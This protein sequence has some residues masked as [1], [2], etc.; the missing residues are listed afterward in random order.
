MRA[1]T[2]FLMFTGQAEEALRFYEKAFYI[3]ARIATIERYGAEG[4]GV[5]GTVKRAVLE[6]GALE[7]L[8][9]DSPPVHAF[10]FTP[11]FSFMVDF[12][13][14]EEL[15]LVAGTLAEGGT[16]LMPSDRY[17]F[18]E[19]YTWLT[20]RFGVSWQLRVERQ[21]PVAPLVPRTTE[22]GGVTYHSF[23]VPRKPRMPD[24]GLVKFF[25]W[26]D[27]P[28]DSDGNCRGDD[29]VWSYLY[30][31]RRD[32]AAPRITICPVPEHPAVLEISSES[33]EV[34]ARGALFLAQFLGRPVSGDPHGRF[35]P[36]GQLM[37]HIGAFDVE[38]AWQRVR[39][40][41]RWSE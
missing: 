5:A 32:I 36:Y 25:V 17:P 10:G 33:A 16:T 24:W 9:M 28:V 13:E 22:R 11:S 27:V 31:N 29:Q 38:A 4:P 39:D 34:A 6:L 26:G 15:D 37:N 1:V 3:N 40:E 41:R 2:P 12:D 8:V 14:A 18:A 19:R 23:F 35:R 30:Q 20:D 21:S 7:I